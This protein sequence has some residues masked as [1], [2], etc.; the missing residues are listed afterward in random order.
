MEKPIDIDP[1][2]LTNVI[3]AYPI[4]IEGGG[5]MDL[6]VL[7]VGQ[8]LLLKGGHNLQR[9]RHQATCAIVRS[10]TSCWPTTPSSWR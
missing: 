10:I 9:A 4:D 8:N 6:V 1:K 5:H 3:G 2:L 7:R